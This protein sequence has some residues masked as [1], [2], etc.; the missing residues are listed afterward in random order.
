MPE[1]ILGA[2]EEGS[3]TL[4]GAV[5]DS[6]TVKQEVQEQQGRDVEGGTQ[7]DVR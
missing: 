2:K 7:D 3:P 4:E 1:D 5:A 6:P